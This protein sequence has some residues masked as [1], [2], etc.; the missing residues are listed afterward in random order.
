MLKSL[1][2]LAI[3]ASVIGLIFAVL[4]YKG[5]KRLRTLEQSMTSRFLQ[6]DRGISACKRDVQVF[7]LG[8]VG[9]DEKLYQLKTSLEKL[10]M[11][12]EEL[13]LQDSDSA[14]YKH[15]AK[16]F[17]MGVALDEVVERC[18]LKREEAELMLTMQKKA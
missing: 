18:G 7:C 13:S 16:L 6:V 17:E 4:I 5:Y 10:S 8:N 12:H 2:I 1:M 9:M 15:A 3:S 11:K 14:A